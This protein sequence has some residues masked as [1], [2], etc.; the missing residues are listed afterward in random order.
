MRLPD[1]TDR[2][3]P[4]LAAAMAELEA[5]DRPRWVLPATEECYPDLLRAGVRL[6]RCHDL[7]LTESILLA[8]AGT[9]GRPRNLAAAAAR[10]HGLPEPADRPPPS[11]AEV[12]GLFEL[13]RGSVPAG[14]PLAAAAAVYADQQRRLDADPHPER[15]R[16]LVAAES[17]GGLA[18]A[19]MTHH[20]L[21]WRADVHDALLTE[22]LGPR[23]PA[24]GK[25][26]RLVELADE[27]SAAFGGVAVNPD[28]PGSVVRAFKKAGIEVPSSRAW[29]LREVSH[30]AVPPLL[31]YKELARL[32]VAHGWTW[33]DSWVRAG[34]FRPEY[35]VGGVVSGRWATRGGAALQLPKTLRT[36][37]RA[38]PGWALVTADAAQLEPR[39]LAA[40]SGDL[41]LAEV[42]G[43]A[44]LYASLAADAFD[45][46]RGHAKVAMLSAM[47]GGTSGGA[48]PLLAV[49]RKR[50]P[51]AVDYVEQAARTGEAGGIVRS[52]LG[53]TSPPPSEAWR[54]LTGSAEQDDVTERRS[55]QAARNWGRFTRNFVVQAS[56]ADWALTV[57]AALRRRLT[58]TAPGAEVVFFQHDEVLVHCPAELAETVASEVD[59]AAAEASH[60]VFG[61]TPVRFPLQAN[62]VDC[63]ADAK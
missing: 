55:R 54:A 25:P 15:L 49:L 44:D 50:F 28:A 24:G 32:W 39:V 5:R 38:D 3:V 47:Y 48:G 10:L 19:E 6:A 12:P 31:R 53:R 41:R 30:P 33:L 52:R 29:V 8:C 57:L 45:G 60:L 14:D 9:P 43:S 62:I 21:P 51:H 56:A 61:P 36:A 2:A 16:L 37:V 46:D 4:D 17:A 1:G 11:R 23:P 20:G 22:L 18:A 35:V 59:K 40:L 58:L 27:I 7:A 42:S 13:D 34:R 26:A 63:Y